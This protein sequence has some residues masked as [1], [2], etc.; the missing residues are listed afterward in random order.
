MGQGAASGD[1]AAVCCAA[2]DSGGGLHAANGTTAAD[3]SK[4]A[5]EARRRSSK[6]RPPSPQGEDGSCAAPGVAEDPFLVSDGNHEGQGFGA[7]RSN[8]FCTMACMSERNSLLGVTPLVARQALFGE[9][10]LKFRMANIKSRAEEV[11]ALVAVIGQLD[12]AGGSSAMAPQMST[13][14][15]CPIPATEW[16]NRLLQHEPALRNAPASFVIEACR[17]TFAGDARRPVDEEE[18]GKKYGELLDHVKRL[19]NT[20]LEDS[21]FELSRLE[22]AR[23]DVEEQITFCFEKIDEDGDNQ[24]SRAGFVEFVCGQGDEKTSTVIAYPEDVADFFNHMS[25]GEEVLTYEQFK[26]EVTDGCLMLLHKAI[27]LRRSQRKR[28]RDTWF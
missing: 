7:R 23:D 19:L 8:G 13:G 11:G 6:P 4:D 25:K 27:D 9:R 14:S 22:A 1:A 10:S 2:R 3:V 24:I 28:F 15:R 21:R 12:G 17:T 26:E 5:G 18:F 20:R 16:A